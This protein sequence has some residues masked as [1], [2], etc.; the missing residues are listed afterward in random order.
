M[1]VVLL[2]LLVSSCSSGPLFP[3]EP[4]HGSLLREWAAETGHYLETFAPDLVCLEVGKPRCACSPNQRM[5]SETGVPI[6]ERLDLITATSVDLELLPGVGPRT[7]ERIMRLRALNRLRRV[8]DL[9]QIR[10]IGMLRLNRIRGL[11]RVGDIS[12]VIDQ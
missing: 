5:R 10:G 4:F 1:R 12:R 6:E 3:P 2:V 9:L 8:D 11:V 7:A